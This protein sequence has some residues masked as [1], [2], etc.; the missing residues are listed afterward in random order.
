MQHNWTQ[1][2]RVDSKTKSN[3]VFILQILSW[4]VKIRWA[5]ILE[6]DQTDVKI[7]TAF[8]ASTIQPY[9]QM[10]R[11]ILLAFEPISP[12]LFTSMKNGSTAIHYGSTFKL[13]NDS[14]WKRNSVILILRFGQH[15][16]GIADHIYS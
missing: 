12:T 14:D 6:S 11:E 15:I 10:F 4:K 2:W 1:I 8:V 16:R 7:K 3:N 9:C 5:L 13:F